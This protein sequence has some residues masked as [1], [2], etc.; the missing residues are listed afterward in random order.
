MSSADPRQSRA[1]TPGAKTLRALAYEAL[2]DLIVNQAIAPGSTVTEEELVARTGIGRT[3]VREA[4]QR[5]AREGLVS[6]RPRSSIVVL[7][8]TLARQI[9]LLEVR[10][11]LQEQV[12]RLA[13]RRADLDRR[14]RMLL[15]A[16]AV[17]DAAAIGQG[18]L[19][20]R[21]SRD[22]HHL[23]CESAGNEFLERFMGSLYTLSR[24]F[25]FA[26]LRSVDVPRGAACH[27]EV[28][29]AVAGRDEEAAAKASQ[30]MME[31]LREFTQDRHQPRVAR[32]RPSA[33]KA[34]TSRAQG[35]L[36]QA[37]TGRGRATAARSR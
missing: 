1:R 22:I 37:P 13:A 29:R 5:L 11:A 7:E 28:L 16:G 34:R 35:A 20:L 15:L 8:M 19:Y 18:E 14:S 26:H 32:N 36:E 10:A 3:P 12:V 25:S 27:A 33:V 30:R 31:F 9:Q 23:L 24:Q 2:E 17:E 4:L 21:I 6:I